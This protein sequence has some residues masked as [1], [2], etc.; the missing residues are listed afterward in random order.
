MKHK[1][2]TL[3]LII[4]IIASSLYYVWIKYEKP[5]ENTISQYTN[6]S[7][8]VKLDD[9][10]IKT[11]YIIYQDGYKYKEGVTLDDGYSFVSIPINS[12]YQVTSVN[13]ED[14]YYYSIMNT[15]VAD[16]NIPY[17]SLLNIKS[18]GELRVSHSLDNKNQ[19]ISID[20]YSI[21]PYN[22][23]SYCIDWSDN[24]IWVKSL[25]DIIADKLYFPS[26]IKC[27]DTRITLDDSNYLIELNYKEWKDINQD[28][29]IKIY[30]FDKNYENNIIKYDKIGG[31]DVE[32]TISNML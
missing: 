19:K 16:S 7:I 18:V 1:I 6:L 23:I 15:F 20:I 21:G 32:Y 22:D 27:F 5:A 30:F 11:G 8:A 3:C 10:F 28:D 25:N 14:Q 9:E 29:Y 12:T 17:R 13:L 31:N 24:I 4:F 2:I 26:Y